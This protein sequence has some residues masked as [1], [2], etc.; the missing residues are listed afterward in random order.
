MC[1]RLNSVPI[2]YP[3]ALL[4][5]KEVEWSGVRMNPGRRWENEKEDAYSFGFISHYPALLL[6]N[7][8]MPQVKSVLFMTTI[9]EQY[10]V[11]V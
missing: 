6:K 11:L 9:P 2:P 3:P 1:Y 10:P 5:W 7:T 8:L 4:K